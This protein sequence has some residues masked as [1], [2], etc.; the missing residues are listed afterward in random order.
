MIEMVLC[1]DLACHFETIGQANATLQQVSARLQF[2]HVCACQVC[3][4]GK[5]PTLGQASAVVSPASGS[6]PQGQL[7]QPQK[8][9][10]KENVQANA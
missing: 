4:D 10:Q 7:S 6:L 9:F 2:L 1:T 5:E 8:E 3:F